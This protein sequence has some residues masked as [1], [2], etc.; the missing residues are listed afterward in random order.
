MSRY[1]II[2]FKIIFYSFL[3]AQ[4]VAVLEH[5]TEMGRHNSIVQVDSDTY[6]LA[7]SDENDKGYI[8]TFTI[9][10]NGSS[11]T[12]VAELKHDN[13]QG[14]YNSFIQLDSDTYVLAYSGNGNDGYIK[15][16][17]ISSNGATIT[18]VASLEHD[19]NTGQYNSLV[20]VDSDTYALAYGGPGDDGYIVT[21][22]IPA[23]GS[24]IT[25]VTSLEHDTGNGINNSLIQADSDT[26]V[27]AYTGIGDDGFISTFT[28]SADGSTITEVANI[29]H[30]A[31]YGHHNSI[32]QVDSDTYVLA[33][34]GYGSDGYMKTFT[35]PSNGA[36]I[37]HVTTLEFD[38]VNDEYN[39][40]LQVDSD[41]YVLAYTGLN[42][43]GYISTFTIPANG[44]S[45]TK[46]QEIEHDVNKGRHNSIVQ[47]DSDTYVLAYE[48]ENSDGFIKTFSVASD[49]SLPV[50]LSSFSLVSSRSN[51]MTLE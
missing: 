47:V 4:Q 9:P 41:T 2:L 35:I 44:S 26:Y 39:S 33:Y 23:D 5:D 45:I 3:S 8:K 48:G 25:E 49:G 38:T 22:T 46:V 30:E 27:L 14:F 32:A 21:F 20:Q 40:L 42:D 37:T 12:E 50:D 51:A 43:D 15:T 19:T 31:I 36:S 16:F 17:T 13:N 6:A 7:C 34:S 24:S 11:I 18:E 28:I 29:E 1:T 10:S